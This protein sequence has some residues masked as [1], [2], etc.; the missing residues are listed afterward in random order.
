M[1][2]KPSARGINGRQMNIIHR[3]PSPA[4]RQ[5]NILHLHAETETRCINI[6]TTS[7]NTVQAQAGH[8]SDS[9]IFFSSSLVSN[10][11]QIIFNSPPDACMQPLAGTAEPKMIPIK[12]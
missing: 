1:Q 5:I 7:A 10:I 9:I 11:K 12:R 3:Q 8:C 6:L 2:A 4:L